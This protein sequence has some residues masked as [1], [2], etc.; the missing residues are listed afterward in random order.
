MDVSTVLKVQIVGIANTKT[1]WFLHQ[2][3]TSNSLEDI[4]SEIFEGKNPCV[5]FTT[6]LELAGLKDRVG[7]EGDEF[8]TKDCVNHVNA[9]CKVKA[10]K[11]DE[12]MESPMNLTINN[13]GATGGFA[14]VRLLAE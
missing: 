13:I 6:I 8:N 14:D 12:W 11:S 3:S 1:A 5:T 10:V 2:T 9:R 4:L 7:A